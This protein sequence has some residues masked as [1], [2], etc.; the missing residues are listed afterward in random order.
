MMFTCMLRCYVA[1]SLRTQTF[2]KYYV[3]AQSAI[4]IGAISVDRCAEIR[5]APSMASQ[6]SADLGGKVPESEA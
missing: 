1:S 3:W 4:L 5:H 2:P 6:I